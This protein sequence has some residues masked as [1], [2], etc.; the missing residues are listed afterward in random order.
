M[1]NKAISDLTAV[2]SIT[3]ATLFEVE[4]GDVS[5]KATGTQFTT[6]FGTPMTAATYDP[7][8]I[9]EQLVGLTATQT[10]TGKTLTTPTIT[11]KQGAAPA[12]TAEGDVQWDTDDNTIKVG[13]G[14]G[15]K[16]FSDD[17]KVALVANNLSDMTAA[18]VRTNLNLVIGTDAQAWDADLDALAG[19]TSAANKVPMFSGSGTAT[20]LDFKDE[21]DLVSDSATAV[22]S[23][24]SIKAYVDTAVT[25]GVSDGDKGDITV[26][27]SGSVWTIDADTV[28]YDKM[29]D[30]SATDV[31]LGRSTAGAGT[32][33]EI[34]CTAFGRSI[35]DDADE[36]TF[37]ATV[38]LEP[39]TDVQAYDSVLDTP[40]G[41]QTIW[42]PAVAMYARTTTG[43]ASGSTELATNDVMVKT[44]DFDASADEH[45]QFAIQMPKNWDEGT[46]VFQAVW[47]HPSTDTNFGVVF[48]MQAVAFANDDALD[49]AF[50]TAVSVTDTGGTTDDLYI[51]PES[52]ALTVAGTPGAEEYV[53]FQI[54][55][56]VSDASDTMAVDARL[57]G[58]KIHYTTDVLTDD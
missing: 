8:G 23:Q 9:E 22:A 29:Q 57:H 27:S 40:V 4:K 26:S 10:L 49:T 48:F 24:Q 53:V 42:V 38:N 13:D 58:V 51:S 14:S 15:T 28:T 18:T 43:A 37:K 7:A 47:S 34:A 54:Y 21:D 20:L 55:R 12:P 31:L 35:L 19:L 30:T 41:Q 6:Y 46:L 44:F 52:A 50:G 56:D 17:S 3:D 36:A 33:E 2:D 45:V 16:T 1:A 5:Y 25:G 32:V 11:L 39:G